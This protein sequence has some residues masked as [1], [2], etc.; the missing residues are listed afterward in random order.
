M[1]V[2]ERGIRRVDDFQQRHAVIAFPFAVAKKFGDDR[3]GYLAALIAYYAF[4]S[5]FPLL[6]AFVSILGLVLK[7]NPGLYDNVVNGTLRSFPLIGKQIASHTPPRSVVAIVIGSVVAIWAGLSVLSAM[8]NAM[9]DV[10][11]LPLKDR[12]NFVFNRLRSLLMLALFGTLT[13]TAIFLTG[14]GG[15]SGSVPVVWRVAG[16]AI[17]LVLNWVLYMVGFRV[18]TNR[19]LSWRDVFPG[20]VFGAAL[21]TALQTFGNYLVTHQMAKA[22]DTYGSF[23]LVIGLLFWFYLAA[24]LSVYAAE[25]NVVRSKRLWPRS[26]MQPPLS[27]GDKRAYE[28]MAQVEQ[29]RPE[30]SVAVSFHDDE[31]GAERASTGERDPS[32]APGRT[33]TH[34]SR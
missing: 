7:H 26:L 10:W 31:G 2:V 6:F 14:I 19:D 32:G 12:P 34:G 21:W 15:T 23:A 18:L 13:V 1:N 3:A 17:S 25:I 29:R 11:D 30:E 24:Q 5:I 22:S 8:Q 28:Q 9:N 27:E 20:A 16:V 4:W 33:P